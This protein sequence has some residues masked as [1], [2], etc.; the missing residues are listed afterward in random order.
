MKKQIKVGFKVPG[1]HPKTFPLGEHILVN[2]LALLFECLIL[3]P[4]TSDVLGQALI[5]H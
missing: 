3:I 5:E 4:K 1:R 2:L